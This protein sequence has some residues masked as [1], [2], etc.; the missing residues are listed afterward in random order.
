MVLPSAD[1]VNATASGTDRITFLW[2][3]DAKKAL[4]FQWVPS[5]NTQ[6]LCDARAKA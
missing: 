3:F 6:C 1:L 2:G 4:Y 5:K